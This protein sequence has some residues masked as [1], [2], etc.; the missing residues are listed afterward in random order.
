M[1]AYC[2]GGTESEFGAVSG[3]GDT[4][5]F[6]ALPV[7]SAEGVAEDAYKKLRKKKQVAFYGFS[8]WLIAKLSMLSP[9]FVTTSMASWLNTKW[10]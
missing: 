4:V 2:P 5:L 10:K 7:A 3:N 8:G 1:C 6:N 9:A